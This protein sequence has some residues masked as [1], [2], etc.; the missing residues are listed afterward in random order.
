MKVPIKTG[1]FTLFPPKKTLYYV[2]T[3]KTGGSY[4]QAQFGRHA[5]RCQT[6]TVKAARG[7]RTWA[8]YRKI[9][10][11]TGID[12][13][14]VYTFTTVRNPWDWHVS[15]FHYIRQNR[16]ASGYPDEHDLF[17]AFSFED[18]VHWL[19][20]ADGNP[21]LQ[22]TF[23]LADWAINPET[24]QLAVNRVLRQET[25]EDDLRAM[26]TDLHLDIGVKTE[27]VNTSDRANDY[28]SYYND[29]TAQLIADRHGDDLRLFGY[30]F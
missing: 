12:F 17:Q 16:S 22:M 28:R 4:V 7:H 5:K 11:D 18:Y 30:S 20:E 15:F 24:G 6:L 10:A 8:E 26:L 9:F 3:P 13:E 29:T 2:H 27:S 21:R 25:L 14:G 19:S 1:N 23:Q